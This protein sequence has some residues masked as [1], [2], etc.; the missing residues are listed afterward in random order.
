MQKKWQWAIDFLKILFGCALFGVG[1][2]MFL[3]PA[4]LN[5]GGISGIGMIFVEFF[6]VGTVGGITTVINIP[7]FILAAFL[8][9]RRFFVGSFVGMLALSAA[10]DLLAFLPKVD[11]EPI[12]CALYGGILAGAGLGVVFAT[13]ASTGGSD[14]IIRVL[15][16]RWRN[17]PIGVISIGFDL[18]VAAL[19]G[20]VFKDISCALYSGI[21]IFI[22]GKV[23]DLVVYSFD[24][25]K[26]ALI[27]TDHYQEVAER[28]A[29]ELDRGATYLKGEGSYTGKEKKVILTA[30]K[31]QQLAEL[32]SLVVAIDPDAFVIV[33]EAHQVLGDG[34][35]RYSKD[36]L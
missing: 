25:S 8:L 28:I 22:T 20:L 36:S 21:A 3:A 35:S 2:N 26:V 30:V 9:G 23:I 33:Q 16:L 15:K 7:L 13:G 1:F 32:K 14:I 31:R 4:G 18:S 5:A 17:T 19:T 34:F 29:A 12:M 11:I 6:G 27:I 10:I 24:Y